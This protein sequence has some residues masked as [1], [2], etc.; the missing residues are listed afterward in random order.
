VSLKILV[1]VKMKWLICS[2]DGSA[3]QYVGP[4]P[5]LGISEQ[6]IT[7]KIMGWLFNST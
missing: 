2:E 4:E 1:Q 7:P 3:P 5:T 6:N